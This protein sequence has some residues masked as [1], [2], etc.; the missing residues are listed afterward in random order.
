MCYSGAAS[1]TE[2]EWWNHVEASYIQDQ[3]AFFITY[4][5]F[6][7]GVKTYREK[8]LHWHYLK[9]IIII[10]IFEEINWTRLFYFI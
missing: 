1:D 9:K 5:L 7:F 10:I 2:N 3:V 4:Y 6:L 8:I